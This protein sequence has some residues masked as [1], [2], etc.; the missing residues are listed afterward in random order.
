M[1]SLHTKFKWI[2]FF[3]V[4]TLLSSNGIAG[5]LKPESLTA[6]Q[7]LARM[8]DAYKFCKSYSDSGIVQTIYK[9]ADGD[10]TV[11]RPFTTAF[12]RPDHFR[13]EFK[14]RFEFK[15]GDI[16]V[17]G[18]ERYYIVWCQGKDVQSWSDLH[19]PPQEKP[20]SLGEGLSRATGVTGG[21]S[22]TIPCLLLPDDVHGRRLTSVTEAIRAD[23][24]RLGTHECFCIKGKLVNTPITLWIDKGAFL[25]RRIEMQMTFEN[26]STDETTTYYPVINGEVT[27]KMLEF[28]P[29]K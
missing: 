5:A 10:K 29:P 7:I 26:F 24:T 6:E 16:Q 23:D 3:V 20:E 9:K 4:A 15:S 19:H 28:N 22:H 21:S 25:I 1:R 13:F 27:D 17:I 14:D 18:H 8:A 2:F 11:E 12:I